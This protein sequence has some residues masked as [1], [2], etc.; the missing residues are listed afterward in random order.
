MAGLEHVGDDQ[1][2]GGPE[3]GPD[4]E[5][6]RVHDLEPDHERDLPDLPVLESPPSSLATAKA[7]QA[8]LARPSSSEAESGVAHGHPAAQSAGGAGE[9]L[10]A[11]DADAANAVAAYSSSCTPADTGAAPGAPRLVQLEHA[12]G[13]AQQVGGPQG[14][15]QVPDGGGQLGRARGQVSE[16]VSELQPVKE[17]EQVGVT[18]APGG[19]CKSG[20]TPSAVTQQTGIP[21]LSAPG[22]NSASPH[23]TAAPGASSAPPPIIQ[24]GLPS[25]AAPGGSSASPQLA[26]AAREGQQLESKRLEAAH[27]TPSTT[28]P[29]ASLASPPP[30][31]QPGL[32]SMLKMSHSAKQ[33]GSSAAVTAV[34]AAPTSEGAA[35]AG[36]V[37]WVWHEV[38]VKPVVD[39]VTKE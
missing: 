38:E 6:D 39:P 30:L 21:H 22:G 19:A 29:G 32:K 33:Q 36:E 3:Q 37:P 4:G 14:H 2:R 9:T 5:P 26:T 35:A 11:D 15:A 1:Q 8:G 27:S 12:H 7:N 25:Q 10:N 23:S 13:W 28:A 20:C 31:L 16:P 18:T 34:T 17:E 24:P